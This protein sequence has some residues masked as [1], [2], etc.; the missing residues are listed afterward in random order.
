MNRPQHR[1]QHQ[2]AMTTVTKMTT[3]ELA[4]NALATL[5]F[6]D[7]SMPRAVVFD[8]DET[9]IDGDCTLDWIE[10]LYV[11]G[12][13]SD[14]IYRKVAAEMAHRYRAGTLELSWFHDA[15]AP[16][17]AHLSRADFERL[18]ERF[19]QFEI[20]PKI[21]PAGLAQITE[22]RTL[23]IPVLV[24]SASAAFLV[25]P[26][27]EMFGI[28]LENV[29]GVELAEKNGVPSAEIVGTPSFRDGKIARL[30][31]WGEPRGIRPQD[32]IFFTDSRNDLPLARTAGWT[33][34]VNPDDV[35]RGEA[36]TRGWTILRWTR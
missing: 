9:L 13:T 15:V 27:A 11:S 17:C 4:A 1:N 6:P 35:L 8:L 7:G 21:F 34:C 16:A 25:K 10:W 3:P 14:P 12:T 18:L 19:V 29:I 24:I 22:A 23:G 31:E 2:D 36:R 26:V 28:N 30:R 5:R 33:C 20:R 32:V